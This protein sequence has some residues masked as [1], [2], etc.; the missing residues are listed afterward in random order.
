MSIQFS[1]YDEVDRII[2]K[3]VKEN[4]ELSSQQLGTLVGLSASA[5]NE[6]LRKLKHSGIIRK[7]SAQISAEFIGMELGAF[8]FISIDNQDDKNKFLAAIK[9]N[10]SILECHH[11][12]GEFSYII[13]V[14][15]Q[16][17]N[18]LEILI[19]DFLKG[20]CKVTRT[21]S[22]IILSSYKDDSAIVK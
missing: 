15:C 22:Q 19:T 4:A 21:L 18:E 20:K 17:T 7:V 12:T 14:R 9:T 13:K 10:G 5:A 1:E 11:L 8:I 16:N 2:A 6:R 3:T